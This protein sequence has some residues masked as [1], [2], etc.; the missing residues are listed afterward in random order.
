[1]LQRVLFQFRTND[2]QTT[3]KAGGTA[4][5]ILLSRHIVEVDPGAILAGHDSLG[6]ENHAIVCFLAQCMQ[7]TRDFLLCVFAG[8]FCPPADEDLIGIMVMPAGTR[9]VVMMVLMV[10]VMMFFVPVFM[11]VGRFIVVVMVFMVMLMVVMMVGFVM[12]SLLC[13]QVCQF[14]FQGILVFHGFQDRF[15]IQLFPWCG[16]CLLY[17]SDA[18]DEL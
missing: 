2:A 8:S 15:P 4:A 6:A 7:R 10:M 3:G 18:A 1:M 16:D 9:T 14:L 17:T 11:F 5:N 12:S 13:G